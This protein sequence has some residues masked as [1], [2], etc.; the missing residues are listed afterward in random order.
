MSRDIGPIRALDPFFALANALRQAGFAIAP[1]QTAG[2]IAA[3]GALGPRSLEDIRR[4]ALALFAIPPERRAEFDAIFRALFEGET[5]SAEAESDDESVD[6]VEPEEGSIEV[7]V[8]DADDP[9]GEEASA[10]ERLAQRNLLIGR[11]DAAHKDF[12]RR[13][14]K[15]LPRRLSYRRKRVKSGDRIDLKQALRSASRTGGDLM[16]LPET[17]RKSRQ[18]RI[19]LLIDVSGSMKER[20][21]TLLHFAHTLAQNAEKA[22]VFTLGTRLTRITGALSPKDRRA[23]LNRVSQSVSDIDGGTRIGEALTAFLS[24]P[25]YQGFA[26]GAL[27]IVLSDGL[28]RGDPSLMID[29]V[30]RLSRIAYQVHWLT[31]LGADPGYR[32]E[33]AAL[34]A[35]LPVLDALSDGSDAAAISHHVLNLAR[36]A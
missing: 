1:D 31:P 8:E 30:R 24:V 35:V 19:L 28:E 26:R 13:A 17:R 18:R 7:D 9:S 36:A 22:E 20:S 34:S 21:D 27:A 10:T 25:R 4:A 23:A 16:V 11:E 5:I 15:R 14:P 29:A 32:P 12:A 6:A 2:F 33:T 3:I